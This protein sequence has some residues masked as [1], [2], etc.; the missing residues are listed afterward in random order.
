MTRRLWK[1]VLLNMVWVTLCIVAFDK[2]AYEIEEFNAGTRAFLRTGQTSIRIFDR[3]GLPVSVI[4]KTRETVISP[5]YVVHYGLLH[6]E[7]ARVTAPQ[8]G[9]HWRPD[10]SMAMWNVPPSQLSVDQ[11]KT[12]ADW[13]VTNVKQTHGKYHLVYNFEWSYRNYAGGKLQSPWWS[14][15]T[16]GYALLLMLRAYDIYKDE[17]YLRTADVLYDAVV[18]PL[19]EGGS[20]IKLNGLPWVEEYVDPAAPASAMPRVLNGMIYAYKGIKAYELK[21]TPTRPIAESLRESILANTELFDI[22]YWSWYDQIENAANIKYHRIHVALLADP[23]FSVASLETLRS[24]WGKGAQHPGFFWLLSPN[25]SIAK[26]HL[27]I[28][29]ALIA[30]LLLILQIFRTIAL[31]VAAKRIR[32]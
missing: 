31:K 15:L 29:L 8:N 19:S 16:D 26:I 24:R 23:D 5:F 6:S 11:F 10:P 14:G 32:P 2:F 27:I 30:S 28:D 25:L 9:E 12:N 7:A 18:S 13:V 1:V 22:G 3:D 17:K 4:A 21:R 20:L